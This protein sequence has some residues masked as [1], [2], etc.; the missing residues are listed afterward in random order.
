MAAITQRLRFKAHEPLFAEGEPAAHVFNVTSGV[1]KLYKLMPDGRRQITG[2]LGVGDFLGMAVGETYAYTAEALSDAWVCRFPRARL[3]ALLI[4]F[5]QL[6]R[7]L[8]AMASTELRA[9]QDQ[10]LL[11]GRKTAKERLCSF[12]LYMSQRAVRSGEKASPIV[13]PMTRSDIADYLGLTIET[14]SRTLTQLKAEG[15]ID[16][17]HGGKVRLNDETALESSAGAL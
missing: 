9:A 13:L 7:R 12:L 16:L 4:E 2:F 3:E 6:Q 15:L 17:L 14:V 11:L 10:M 1:V 8:F 5:P